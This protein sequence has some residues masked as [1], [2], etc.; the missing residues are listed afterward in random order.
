MNTAGIIVSALAIF[1]IAGCSRIA[2][3]PDLEGAVDG[4]GCD[5]DKEI[6]VDG[7]CIYSQTKVKSAFAADKQQWEEFR[8]NVP[9][10]VLTP[11]PPCVEPI[12]LPDDGANWG[13]EGHGI[14]WEKWSASTTD[15]FAQ[16]LAVSGPGYRQ[17][18]G[19]KDKVM[20]KYA[21][22]ALGGITLQLADGEPD[23]YPNKADFV[24]N[25]LMPFVGDP[26]KDQKAAAVIAEFQGLI[27]GMDGKGMTLQ[28]MIK[29]EPVNMLR[30]SK[31]AE[32]GFTK[33]K[34]GPSSSEDSVFTVQGPA[35]WGGSPQT[36]STPPGVT[37][38]FI[39]G[40]FET[41]RPAVLKQVYM[42]NPDAEGLP[43]GY[44]KATKID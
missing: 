8:K 10:G 37:D 26:S 40:E 30:A 44:I 6:E 43:I 34:M 32:Q 33:M 28:W 15:C 38:T 17:Y 7:T 42:C 19:K 2:L 36:K 11:L 27:P 35:E 25:A 9:Q 4:T 31:L 5:N 23:L 12:F 29:K 14:T 13:V 1:G 20:Y 41:D 18:L 16:A 21:D 39:V 3:R 24:K 22:F